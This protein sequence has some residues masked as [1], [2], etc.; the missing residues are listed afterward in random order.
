[1]IVMVM[2]YHYG[3]NCRYIFDLTRNLCVALGAKP[4]ERAASLAEYGVEEDAEAAGKFDKV[5]GVA[6]PCCAEGGCFAGGEEGWFPD[7]D[8]WR[9]CIWA[10]VGA[11]DAS[12]PEH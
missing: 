7:C 5:A 4:A 12:P 2:R 1:M 11:G 6:E 9:C 10:V 3:I 8:G